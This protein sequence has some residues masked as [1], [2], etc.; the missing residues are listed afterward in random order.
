MANKEMTAKAV[1]QQIRAMRKRMSNSCIFRYVFKPC[2]T[3]TLAVKTTK[4]KKVLVFIII[5]INTLFFGYC[6]FW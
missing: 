3:K 6:Y 2:G 1:V 4:H 5:I